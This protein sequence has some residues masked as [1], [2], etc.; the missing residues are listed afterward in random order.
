MAV[1][2][3]I[4]DSLSQMSTLLDISPE[5]VLRRVGLSDTLTGDK[6]ISV[7]PETFFRLRDAACAEANRPGVETDLAMA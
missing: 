6:E 4:G 2:Y 5:R 1:R 7:G 3:P